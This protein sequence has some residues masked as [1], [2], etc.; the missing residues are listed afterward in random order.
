METR[1]ADQL[2]SI[3]SGAASSAGCISTLPSYC[4]LTLTP[5]SYP[6]RFAE[7]QLPP[8]QN[9]SQLQR[10]CGDST[11]PPDKHVENEIADLQERLAFSEQ[12]QQE[13]VGCGSA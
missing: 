4:S 10:V 9:G 1:N 3:S 8:G 5:R 7:A 11:A 2:K 13:N 12:E 6:R